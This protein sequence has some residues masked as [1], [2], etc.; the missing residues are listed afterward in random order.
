MASTS[1]SAW[2]SSEGERT[3][4]ER[5]RER[6]EDWGLRKKERKRLTERLER[7]MNKKIINHMPFG[8]CTVPNL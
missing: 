3:K 5:L 8:V 7:E 4:D 1:A 6:G 2:K